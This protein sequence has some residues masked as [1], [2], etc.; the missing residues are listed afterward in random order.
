M[1][2]LDSYGKPTNKFTTPSGRYKEIFKLKKMLEDADIMFDWIPHFGY[3]EDLL[4][5]YPD[6]TEH[7]QICYPVFDCKHRYI[8]CIEGFGTYGSQDDKLEIMGGLTKEESA[9]RDCVVG[10]LTA[11]NV[12]NRIKEHWDKTHNDQNVK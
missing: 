1:A 10:W 8:S 9:D 7:Y 6:L 3:P 11:E 12:F 4:D 5:R 2:T